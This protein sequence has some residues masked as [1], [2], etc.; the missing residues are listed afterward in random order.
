M[1]LHE[2]QAKKFL[3]EYGIPTPKGIVINKKIDTSSALESLGGEAVAKAQVYAGGRGQS[4]GI[5]KVSS[6]SVFLSFSSQNAGGAIPDL[7]GSK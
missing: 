7:P 2:Y 6:P 1:K 5:I 4:G 3:C